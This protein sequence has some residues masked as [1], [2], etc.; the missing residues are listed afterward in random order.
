MN[1]RGCLGM[2]LL[3]CAVGTTRFYRPRLTMQQ[4]CTWH[5]CQ[6]EFEGLIKRVVLDHAEGSLQDDVTLVVVAVT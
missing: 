2:G 1:R 6:C 3:P 5:Q 4:W